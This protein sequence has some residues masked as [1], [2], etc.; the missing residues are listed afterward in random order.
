MPRQMIEEE[1]KIS[2]KTICKI[3]ENGR[4][5]LGLFC[6]VWLMNRRLSDYRLL[7]SL[8]SLWMMI[9]DAW[10]NCN[11]WWDLVFPVWSS[12]K[13]TKLEWCL[14]GSLR[15]KR[16]WFQKSKTKW[17]WSTFFDNQGSFTKNL[18]HHILWW[19]RNI[20]WKYFLVWFKEFVE[21]DLVSGKRKLVSLA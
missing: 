1:L 7:R 18:F 17:C 3:L 8:F 12:N 9:V 15:H 10:L 2:R 4:S 21:W 6:T 19:I 20:I 14:A 16:F 13:M 11:R 5:G